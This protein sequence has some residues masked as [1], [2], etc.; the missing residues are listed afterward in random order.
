MLKRKHITAITL[1]LCVAFLT[2]YGLDMQCSTP[3]KAL[4]KKPA[5]NNA[6]DDF[7]TGKV[8]AHYFI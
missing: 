7:F 1:L 8:Q 6:A 3:K 2:S 5:I 4:D